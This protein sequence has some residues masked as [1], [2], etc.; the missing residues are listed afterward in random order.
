M[1]TEKTER[2]DG[3][4]RLGPLG[5]AF[6]AIVALSV[7]STAFAGRALY[8]RVRKAHQPPAAK[9]VPPGSGSLASSGPPGSFEGLRIYSSTAAPP[10]LVDVDGDGVEDFV[11]LVAPQNV[12]TPDVYATA[13]SGKTL[14]PIWIRGPYAVQPGS[15]ARLFL[16]GDRLV[17][18]RTSETLA[19]AHVLSVHTGGEVAAYGLG[20]PLSGACGAAGDGRR[21]LLASGTV[22]DL[23]T[24]LLST[25]AQPA[26]CAAEWPRCD[27][28]NERHCAS[29]DGVAVKGDTLDPGYTYHD[30]G[31]QVSVGSLRSSGGYARP[32]LV[33]LGAARG[34]VVWD[35]V[36][37][38]VQ[39]PEEHSVAGVSVGQGRVAVLTRE[40]GT[41][42]V[43]RVLD[44][45]T[46]DDVWT[47]TIDEG[48][49]TPMTIHTGPERVFATFLRGGRE[50][51]RVYEAND[52]KLVGN[53]ADVSSDAKAPGTP[54]YGVKSYRGRYYGYPSSPR[55]VIE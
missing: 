46:G 37:S 25:P 11:T 3:E 53:I 51:V 55:V 33:V 17:L 10:K 34:R 30:E 1:G 48:G 38:S 32:T 16:A 40:S 49:L 54:G 41:Q 5:I 21:L 14:S 26:S 22:L 7:T 29:R 24:G 12:E 43:V 39:S 9:H 8:D 52:G 27:G 19:S 18:A 47:D 31:W 44:M 28:S 45:R 36:L 50:E 13:L 6:A 20:E 2:R 42:N 15:P 23:E 4:R 35:E